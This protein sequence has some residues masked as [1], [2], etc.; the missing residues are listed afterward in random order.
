MVAKV[1]PMNDSNLITCNE[2][3]TSFSPPQTVKRLDTQQHWLSLV[4]SR[5]YTT[6]PFQPWLSIQV[7][8]EKGISNYFFLNKSLTGD[9]SS[10]KGWPSAAQLLQPQW[11]TD[12][13]SG[14]SNGISRKV[15]REH[16]RSV[17]WVVQRRDD[18]DTIIFQLEG[19]MWWEEQ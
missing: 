6:P 16:H 14:T 10:V 19:N 18:Y 17:V 4:G 12:T 8:C 5:S 9:Q 15:S 2:M 11:G 7:Q 13:D 3:W 1:M